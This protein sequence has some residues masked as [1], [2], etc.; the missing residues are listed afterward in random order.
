MKLQD[1]LI[2]FSKDEIDALCM[3]IDAE[4]YSNTINLKLQGITLDLSGIKI[5][6]KGNLETL[7]TNEQL[8]YITKLLVM[9]DKK[10]ER[11]N[12]DFDQFGNII[13]YQKN[14]QVKVVLNANQVKFVKLIK[15]Y[16][17]V[18]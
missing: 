15:R 9:K 2:P 5:D 1:G 11:T 13:R 18:H 8:K 16:V 3:L 4:H 10:Y 7:F 14:H 12:L 6:Q 17:N